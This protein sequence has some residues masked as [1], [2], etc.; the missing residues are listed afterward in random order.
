MATLAFNTCN[1]QAGFALLAIAMLASA[2]ARADLYDD[3]VAHSGRP[4]AD[5]KRD[6]IDQPAQM[7]RLAAIRPGMRVGDFMGADGY[8]SELASYVVGPS[9]SVLILN[10]AA[11]D[12]WSPEW[13]QRL[14]GKRLPNVEHRTVDLE[15]LDLPD[16]SLDAALL[17]KVYHDIYVYDPSDPVWPKLDPQRVLAEI[18]R[19]LKPGAVLL[20]VDHSAPAG[21]GTS[22]TVALHR[23]DEA[24]ARSDLARHGF[25]LIATSDALRHPEDPR[26]AISYKGPMLGKT[27]RF[28]MVFRRT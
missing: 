27:D 22:D 2:G 26:N 15:H 12:H 20:L 17:I 14:A 28:V 6:A 7:L 11:W 8:Y 10:N 24:Y 1:V 9:G 3:A 23:I 16:R 13:T 18:A 25:T 5:L 19:V 4:A 21:S